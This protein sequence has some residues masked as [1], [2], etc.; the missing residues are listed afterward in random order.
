MRWRTVAIIGIIDGL[1]ARALTPMA[2]AVEYTASVFR[3]GLEKLLETI[4]LGVSYLTVLLSAI[5]LSSSLRDTMIGIFWL[6][7]L[8][9][10]LSI[11]AMLMGLAFGIFEGK[12]M[13][14][15]Q[16]YLTNLAEAHDCRWVAWG[17]S[18]TA[19]PCLLAGLL[20]SPLAHSVAALGV[21]L[22][23]SASTSYVLYLLS[24]SGRGRKRYLKRRHSHTWLLRRVSNM[25]PISAA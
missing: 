2:H 4:S 13:N 5:Y 14:E 24:N 15:R 12:L 18:L 22:L 3:V 21:S 1:M 20:N 19:A 8:F 6:Y 17:L 7:T 11:V 10:A 9:K 23:I 25:V 16:S